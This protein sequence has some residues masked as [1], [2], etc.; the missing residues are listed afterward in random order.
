MGSANATDLLIVTSCVTLALDSDTCFRILQECGFV[1]TG[2][3]VLVNLLKIPPGLNAEETQAYLR[4]YGA[5]L[6]GSSARVESRRSGCRV[7]A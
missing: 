4:K 3:I 2:G 5:E 7:T 1:P 6:C